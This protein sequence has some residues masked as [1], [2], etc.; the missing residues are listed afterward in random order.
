MKK[1]FVLQLKRLLKVLPPVL[2]VVAVLFGSMT[3]IYGEITKMLDKGD[4]Q[5]K[6]Q[7]ALV[8]DLN[9]SYLELGLAALKTFDSSRMAL[10][11]VPMTM[12][13]AERAME[14]GDIAAIIVVPEAFI[15]NALHGDIRPLKYIT[16]SG[17]VGL[18]SILKD[19][20]TS[21]INNIMVNT[22]KGIYG[23]GDAADAMGD[24]GNHVYQISL[25]YAEFI[26]DRSK[27]Y[28]VEELGNADQLGLDGYMLCGLS[29]LMLMLVCLPFAPMLVKK[30]LSL[31]RMLAAGRQGATKQILCEF[32]AYFA[33]LLVIL[34]I[35]LTCLSGIGIW[36]VTVP[37][38]LHCI[39]ILLTVGAMSF[40][41]YEISTDLISG[42]L[43]QF[44]VILAMGFISGCLYPIYFFPKSVQTLAGYLPMGI[45]RA[46]LSGCITGVF[47]TGSD[48][49]L[50]LYGVAFFLCAVGVRKWRISGVRG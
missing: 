8:G 50:L 27:V 14:K 26:F 6:A 43:L 15:E 13:D 25:K 49:A 33:G 46:Q 45:A 21:V 4:T 17:A 36:N 28:Q 7:I 47:S 35:L 44:F 30:D 10:E 34:A 41:L 20:L 29:V 32:A 12:K 24:N 16:T 31:G 1:Y 2:L 5:M 19:E 3:L 22:Q 48:T 42:V 23:A 39:P 40:L 9:D 38:V 18:T 11:I 37:A